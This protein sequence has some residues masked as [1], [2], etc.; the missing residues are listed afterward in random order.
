MSAAGP[1]RAAALGLAAALLASGSL[2]ADPAPR[3]AARLTLDN[4][5]FD[6]WLK[7]GDRPDF[8]YTHGTEIAV[9]LPRARRG[10]ERLVP[11]WLHGS[12][13]AGGERALE[14][15]LR[16]DIY[17][18]WTYPPDRPY[19]GWLEVAAGVSRSGARG[20]GEFLLHAGVTGQPSLASAVQR[21]MHRRF[22]H[23]YQP[24]WSGQLPFEPGFGASL[25][26]TRRIAAGGPPGGPGAALDVSAR[27]RLATHAVDLRVALPVS[28]GF[29]M[30]APGS[31]S[32]TRGLRLYVKAHP[33]L[34]LVAR[35]EFLDGPLFRDHPA[36]G[37]K[38]AVV[39]SEVLAGTGWGAF[40]VEWAV[41]RR[42][43]E[44]AGQP[45][46]HTYATLS[47]TWSP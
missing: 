3:A 37:A 43:R 31:P 24:D 46:P 11:G 13:A 28:A 25:A 21:E 33:K 7:P 12:G 39:E 5:H 47:A 27:A 4:D 45:K 35:D 10:R 26:A 40:A 19:A 18:P 32:V 30:P 20:R 41:K 9:S 17:S 14:F 1:R 2:A 16:Q 6:F 15:R 36:P 34:D 29:G 42:S 44:F 8:G 22:N 38:R 23:G